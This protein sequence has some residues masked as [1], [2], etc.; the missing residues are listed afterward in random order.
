MDSDISF[1]YGRVLPKETAP[2]NP[3]HQ[4]K[5]HITGKWLETSVTKPLLKPELRNKT[6]TIAWI[7]SHCKTHGHITSYNI[8]FIERMVNM[9]FRATIAAGNSSSVV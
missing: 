2:R 6:K 4:M 1:L 7:V 9:A 3:N 8:T 5:L